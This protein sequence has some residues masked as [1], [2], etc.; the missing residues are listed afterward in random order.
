LNLNVNYMQRSGANRS[1]GLSKLLQRYSCAE[2]VFTVS[3]DELFEGDE[4]EN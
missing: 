3:A 2:H 1:S 4:N